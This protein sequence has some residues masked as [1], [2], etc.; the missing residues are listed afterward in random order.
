[1]QNMEF[2]FCSEFIEPL[3][4]KDHVAKC[5]WRYEV[6]RARVPLCT[7]SSCRGEKTHDGDVTFVDKENKNQIGNM[8]QRQSKRQKTQDRD[9][10][11]SSSFTTSTFVPN[12]N[13]SVSMVSQQSSLFHLAQ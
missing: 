12:Q 6:N 9:Q 13:S 5:Y 4:Y 10:H 1:M 8:E 2:V 11:T 7:C 3:D